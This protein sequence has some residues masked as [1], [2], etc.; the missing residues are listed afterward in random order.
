MI[1]PRWR[2]WP[3]DWPDGRYRPRYRRAQQRRAIANGR[4]DRGG[5]EHGGRRLLTNCTLLY[6]R[7]VGMR[8]IPAV[9]LLFAWLALAAQVGAGAVVPPAPLAEAFS[10]KLDGVPVCHG[11]DRTPTSPA[12][13]AHHSPDCLI[14]PLCAALALSSVAMPAAGPAAPAPPIAVRHRPGLPP[15]ATAPPHPALLSAQPRGPPSVL[16]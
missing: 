12:A 9:G 11:G 2:P 6:L 13:P 5:R 10:A 14:C 8:R 16:A 4:H 7:A 1:V 3:A 15:P